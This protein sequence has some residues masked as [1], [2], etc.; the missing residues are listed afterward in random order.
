MKS[1]KVLIENILSVG[2]IE[3]DFQNKGLLLLDGDN[4]S[5]VAIKRNG[6]GKS[7]VAGAIYYALYGSFP[8]GITSDAV[9]NRKVGN[10]AKVEYTF[11]S[12]GKTYVVTRTRKKNSVTLTCD[13]VDLTT[14]SAS[15]TN[16]L[17][18]EVVG[19]SPELFTNTILFD[20][21][22]SSKFSTLGDKARK[23]L[24]VELLNLGVYTEAHTLAKEDLKKVDEDVTKVTQNKQQIEFKIQT[25]ESQK[26]HE[27]QQAQ[28]QSVNYDN[29][30]TQLANA[31]AEKLRVESQEYQ[32]QVSMVQ[33]QVQQAQ[34]A[35]S[36]IMAPQET[37]TYAELMTVRNTIDK[38]DRD[39]ARLR[40]E[41]TNVDTMKAQYE[42]SEN[43]PT[44]GNI[45]DAEHKALELGKLATKTTEILT[46][47]QQ[48]KA[49]Y[50]TEHPKLA[51]LEAKE[52]AEKQAKSEANARYQQASQ[53]LT[54]SN[55]ELN[56]LVRAQDN[57][58]SNYN[59]ALNQVKAYE[60]AYV[61]KEYDE[62]INELKAEYQA[63]VDKHV[64]LIKK[65]HGVE[66]AVST[67]S[68]TGVKTRV[69]DLTAP[70]LN[71]R[72]DEYLNMLSGGTIK[73]VL[74]T[75]KQ[76]TTGGK[77]D[78]IDLLVENGFGADSYEGLSA[79]E[80]RRV[81]ISISL[82]LQDLVMTKAELA[83]NLLIYDE[84]FESL[85]EVGCE[86]VIA[87]LQQRLNVAE[88]IIVIT[89]NE[90]LKPLFNNK[91][92]V[93]KENGISTLQ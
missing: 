39:T 32:A 62:Q 21:I 75:Q 46:E 93:V 91:I 26:A 83:T 11:E 18:Q 31:E 27:L 60:D 13:G 33:Q 14:N 23:D 49:L 68:D 71:E 12:K 38:C 37:T 24:L 48:V 42:T 86:N 10:K 5:N 80:K 92:T 56:N 85:D 51:L 25:L 35:L 19:I 52:Q 88:S 69:M 76:L 67:Y 29:A 73:V 65:R 77:S 22:N 3:L 17:I 2:K 58:V 79:G 6:T 50:D 44:C 53:Q 34:E 55:N 66:M 78:K 64:E 61:P 43:C 40:Q 4:K 28:Q 87:L 47:Y 70:F 45:M 84:V 30:K 9:I 20:G 72:I 59:S 16:K 8:S 74:S 90:N 41:L 54:A 63:E 7:T 15:N 81:D 1:I 57:A 36:T 89:H 82:A